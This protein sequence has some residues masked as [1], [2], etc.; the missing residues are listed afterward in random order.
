MKAFTITCTVT[1]SARQDYSVCVG[2]KRND[3]CYGT[4]RVNEDTCKTESGHK[5]YRLSCE[6]SKL[7]DPNQSRLLLNLIFDE[8]LAEDTGDWVCSL[9]DNK[10]VT[11]NVVQ[12]KY[13][14]K[15]SSLLSYASSYMHLSV[16]LC[17]SKGKKNAI[18]I[19][20]NIY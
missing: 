13:K 14:C 4:A 9:T 12:L 1:T 11:S 10:L 15:S 18:L 5:R 8:V 6:W 7:K 19:F 17:L 3:M 16:L 2:P 20:F